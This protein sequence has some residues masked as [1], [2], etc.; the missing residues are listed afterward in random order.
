MAKAYGKL[1]HAYRFKKFLSE[2]AK[3]RL[4]EMYILSQLNYGD[5]ILQNMSKNVSEKFQRVQNSCIRFS[6]GLRKYDHVSLLRKKMGQLTMSN[7][8]MLHGLTLMFKILHETATEPK[9]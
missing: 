1:N 4:C 6:Y 8:R 3:W 7:K 9:F 2:S 5:V